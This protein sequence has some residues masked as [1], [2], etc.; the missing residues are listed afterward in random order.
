MP[1]LSRGVSSSWG[2]EECFHLCSS[3][4]SGSAAKLSPIEH[5]YIIVATCL[6]MSSLGTSDI[7]ALPSIGCTYVATAAHCLK[8]ICIKVMQ[9]NDCNHLWGLTPKK[10]LARWGYFREIF[11]NHGRHASKCFLAHNP[12][13]VDHCRGPI[14]HPSSDIIQ[15]PGESS[16]QNPVLTGKNTDHPW[17]SATRCRAIGDQST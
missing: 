7:L 9:T 3:Q 16:N 10:V 14:E 15:Y 11:S 6:A 12:P 17:S 1:S 8:G 13:Q 5:H 2:P 4:V